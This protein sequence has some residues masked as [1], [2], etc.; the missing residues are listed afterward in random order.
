MKYGQQ[1]I[2]NF[3]K[4]NELYQR[5]LK[6]VPLASQTFSKSA[7]NLVSGASPLFLKEGTGGRVSDVDGNQYIDFVLGL[8]PVVLGYC[9]PDVDAAIKLQLK[10]GISFSLATELEVSLSE[11]LIDLIPSAEKVR[12]GKNGSDATSAA[13]RLARAKTGRDR[14][15]VC[16]YHGWHDWYIGSTARNLGVPTVVQD[17]TSAVPYNDIQAIE[18]LIAAHPGEIAGI[19]LEPAGPV[20]ASPDYLEHLRQ[21]SDDHGIVLIF[22][23]IVSGFRL[24]LG[25]AQAQYG[26][27][28]HLS[29]F[30]KAMGNG[31]PISAI[32]GLDDY[33]SPME[34][35]FFSGTFGGEALSL[36]AS[37]ATLTKLEELDAPAFFHRSGQQMASRTTEILE[38]Y[39]LHSRYTVKGPSWRPLLVTT[40]K[41][42]NAIIATSLLR[43]E[44]VANGLLMGAAFNLCT[45]HDDTTRDEALM[46]IEQAIKTVAA[47]YESNSPEAALRGKKITP[48]FEVRKI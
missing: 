5:A 17:L 2:S 22:D 47:A 7:L 40:E 12:F 16:G 30:G 44:L 45:S 9:D 20:E 35:I 26:V 19:I 37:L 15:V 18:T 4:S 34:D 48:I 39:G 8:L 23:E 46:A 10:S 43:Q 13:I 36:A 14:I 33:M 29:C 41:N 6:S 28:P 42:E 25:G 3:S 32:V 21:I 1:M 11:K 38:K 27:T 31:M 24:H